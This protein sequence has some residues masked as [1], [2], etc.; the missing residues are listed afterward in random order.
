[1]KTLDANSYVLL[2]DY[3]YGS[4]PELKTLK[5]L[6]VNNFEELTIY[7]KDVISEDFD[8][9]INDNKINFVFDKKNLQI[10][11]EKTWRTYE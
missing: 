1:M 3:G 4:E 5:K 9:K 11:L 2:H 7:I 10:L 8:A 6:E